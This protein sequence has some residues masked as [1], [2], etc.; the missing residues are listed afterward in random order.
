MRC[1]AIAEAF[2]EL[3]ESCKY[4]LSLAA[5]RGCFKQMGFFVKD[6]SVAMD[7]GSRNTLLRL[8]GN[9]ILRFVDSISA[10]VAEQTEDNEAYPD[11]APSVLLHQLVRI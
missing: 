9:T 5:V 1:S 7:N 6:Y 4:T 2:H 10:I 3:S 8:S 11:A